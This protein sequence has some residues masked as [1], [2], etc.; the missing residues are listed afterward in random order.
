M[1]SY[2]PYSRCKVKTLDLQTSQFQSIRHG[3]QSHPLPALV[4]PLEWATKQ[5]RYLLRRLVISFWSSHVLCWPGFLQKSHS[6]SR[7]ISGRKSSL[8]TDNHYGIYMNLWWTVIRTNVSPLGLVSGC[9]QLHI[10]AMQFCIPHDRVEAYS[11]CSM[12]CIDIA[13]TLFDLRMWH[14]VVVVGRKLLSLG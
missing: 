10:E 2:I 7:N 11:A 6:W 5:A 4:S 12:K 14:V 1:F 8:H 13:I 3:A 9:C